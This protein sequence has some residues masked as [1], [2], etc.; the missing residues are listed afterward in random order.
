MHS[1][2]NIEGAF[3]LPVNSSEGCIKEILKNYALSLKYTKSQI[4]KS[5]SLL[6]PETEKQKEGLKVLYETLVQYEYLEEMFIQHFGNESSWAVQK[7]PKNILN[8]LKE[9]L[10]KIKKAVQA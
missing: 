6:N 5:L 2:E 1:E 9:A 8:F 10:E 7:Y 4:T 3:F